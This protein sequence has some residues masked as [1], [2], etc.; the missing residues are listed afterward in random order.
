MSN[1]IKIYT[2]RGCLHCLNAKRLLLDEG[3]EFQECNVD[4]N[5]KYLEEFKLLYK[6]TQTDALPTLVVGERLLVPGKSFMEIK[7]I[8]RILKEILKKG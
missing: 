5:T 3:F 1:R 6:I 4:D 2:K 8:P 7:E